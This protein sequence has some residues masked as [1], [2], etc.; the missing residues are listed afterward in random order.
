MQ[1]LGTGYAIVFTKGYA[2]IYID[3]IGSEDTRHYSHLM[4][5]V[6]MVN[7][8]NYFTLHIKFAHFCLLI[9]KK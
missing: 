7:G 3:V 8:T 2:I 6:A 9:I 1:T 4:A 5:N